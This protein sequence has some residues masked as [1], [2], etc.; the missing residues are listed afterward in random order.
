[1]TQTTRYLCC[2]AALGAASLL[3]PLRLVQVSG[4]SM[5]PTFRNGDRYLLD[6]FYY[7]LTG[8]QYDDVVVLNHEGSEIVKR[9]KG[10]PGD[11]LQLMLLSDDSRIAV[12]N[13]TR[14]PE[15][16]RP[17]RLWL[18]ETTVPPN[19][20]FVVG[21]NL[22]VSEDSR[23]FGAVPERELLG[24]VRRFNLVR[25]FPEPARRELQPTAG[26]SGRAEYAAFSPVRGR[27]GFRHGT[28]GVGGPV[29]GGSSGAD[30]HRAIFDD[31]RQPRVLKQNPAPR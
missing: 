22:A 24:L 21:D 17:P 9:V 7:R 27:A 1:M 14:H 11:H 8:I 12:V 23:R 16:R 2:L 6:R 19:A 31:A 20:L 13:I 5:E 4:S 29:E 26:T 3:T 15:L 28:E 10:L 25:S 30:R 18:E